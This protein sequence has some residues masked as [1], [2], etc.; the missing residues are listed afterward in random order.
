MY[1][2]THAR[3]HTG[4]QCLTDQALLIEGDRIAG[5]RPLQEL[6]PALPRHALAG[7]HLTAGFIDLQING[8]GGVMFNNAP[9]LATL[10]TMQAANLRSGTTSFLPTLISAPDETIRTA[11]TAVP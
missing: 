1:A 4:S 6:D 5:L 3:I 7:A 2:L 8:C 9:T 10:Q 11:L